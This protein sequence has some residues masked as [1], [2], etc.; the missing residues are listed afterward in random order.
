[1]FSVN[2]E[3]RG[4]RATLELKDSQYQAAAKMMNAGI[5]ALHQ[6]ISGTKRKEESRTLRRRIE[7]CESFLKKAKRELRIG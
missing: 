5:E 7:E 1:M 4:G 3:T 2:A 6:A